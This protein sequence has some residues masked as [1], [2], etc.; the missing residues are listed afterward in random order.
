MLDWNKVVKPHN[1][2]S[3][4]LVYRTTGNIDLL[5]KLDSS[6]VNLLCFENLPHHC[7]CEPAATELVRVG[8][9]FLAST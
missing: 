3:A 6:S 9:G 4:I 2:P 7:W 1:G 5:V 8:Q